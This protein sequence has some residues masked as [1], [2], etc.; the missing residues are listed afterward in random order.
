MDHNARNA[1]RIDRVIARLQ[2]A[3]AAGDAPPDL[4]ELASVAHLSPFHFHRVYRALTGEPVGRTVLRLRLMRALQALEATDDPITEIAL[5]VGY[6]T[7]QALARVFREQLGA[8]PSELRVDRRALH[9]HL[10]RL[11]LAPGN[12]GAATQPALRVEVATVE[13][14]EVVVLR[15]RGAFSDLDQA[16][17]RLFQW[18]GEADVVE[19]AERLVG[20]PLGDHRDV[21]A[22]ELE[23]DC[24]VSFAVP[25]SPPLPFS[26]YEVGGGRYACARHVGA[27]EGLE[28]LVD[29]MLAEWWPTSGEGLR[30]A[31][32]HYHYLD[33]PEQVPEAILRADVYLPLATP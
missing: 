27:Y 28:A 8:S 29:R 14:F 19:H 7:P 21:E 18:A 16:F 4:A 9:H 33:D 25:V 17:G 30:A 10:Q 1:T 13:P 5:A 15:S 24:A 32:V 26:L 12:A 2:E 31:P 23:F 11:S 3:I 6:E 22:G 20:L